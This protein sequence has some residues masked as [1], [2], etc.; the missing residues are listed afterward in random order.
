MVSKEILRDFIVYF[1][2]SIAR[3]IHYRPM[4]SIDATH[5]YG[6]YQEKLLIAMAQDANNEVYP[7]AFAVVKSKS[8]DS[9]KWF[10]SCIKE[11]VTQRKGICLILDRHVGIERAVQDEHV[12]D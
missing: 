3:F 8:K 9:W 2:P 7:L 5:L 10:L 6:K 1:G 11:D 4:I 12:T